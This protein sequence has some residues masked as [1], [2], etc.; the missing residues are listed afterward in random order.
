MLHQRLRRSQTN[1]RLRH[2]LRSWSLLRRSILYTPARRRIDRQ[3]GHIGILHSRDDLSERIAH[4]A[5]EAESEDCIY[6]M[7]SIL[8]RGSKVLGEGD[9]EVFELSGEAVV[10][11]VG[12]F[13]GEEDGGL[14]AV[15]EEV[16]GCY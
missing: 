7:V 13:L 1:Q 2:E 16:A 4:L 8:Q 10:E 14:V 6:D 15:M 12:G 5:T 3:H 11:L 9:V